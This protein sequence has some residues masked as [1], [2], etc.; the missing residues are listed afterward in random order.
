MLTVDSLSATSLLCL[1]WT[2]MV[3]A[4]FPEAERAFRRALEIEPQQRYAGPNL[5]HLLLA[6]GRAGEAVLHYR[7]IV[8]ETATREG[9]NASASIQLALA[10]RASGDSAGAHPVLADAEWQVRSGKS[11][12]ADLDYRIDLARVLAAKGDARA[13]A[14]L[15][16]GLDRRTGLDGLTLYALSEVHALLADREKSLGLLERAIGAGYWDRYFPLI[17]PEF[18]SL[19]RDPRFWTMYPECPR[20]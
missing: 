20:P 13:A 4:R 12:R 11:R 3:L 14:A 6:T 15:L 18:A 5:A 9:G 10:L 8:R 1:G 16:R 17:A 19:R 7:R 2:R